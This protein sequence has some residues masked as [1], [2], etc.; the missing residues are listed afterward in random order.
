MKRLFTIVAV[1]VMI[2]LAVKANAQLT[3]HAGWQDAKYD[4]TR[5]G[6][7]L[8][9]VNLTGFYA[10]ATYDF[11]LGMASIFLTPGAELSYCTYKA[12]GRDFKQLDL[13]LRFW[14]RWN[15]SITEKIVFGLFAGPSVN[16][17]ISGN[18]YD[19]DY[20]NYDYNYNYNDS[21][22]C[23]LKRADLGLT[24]GAQLRY[25]KIG[26]EGGYNLGLLN[27]SKIDDWEDI[28]FHTIFVGLNFII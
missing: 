16:V 10:G 3:F 21:Y 4:I 9:N 12:Y 5:E 22:A 13:R 18:V 28:K 17:G 14:G 11:D 1:A 24:F 8:E 6:E 20:Y 2:L 19:S 23:D 25:N 26:I 27:R 15:K 7:R